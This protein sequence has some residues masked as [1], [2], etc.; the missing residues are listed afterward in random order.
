MSQIRNDFWIRLVGIALLTALALSSDDIYQQAITGRVLVKLLLTL[1]TIIITWHLNRAIIIAYQTRAAFAKNGSIRWLLIFLSCTV[2]TTVAGWLMKAAEY[3]L[4][5]GT[6]RG[7]VSQMDSIS[8][9]LNQTTLQLST[10]GLDWLHGL[11]NALFYIGVYRIFF[12]LAD[13]S[14]YRQRLAQVEQEKEQLRISNLQSQLEVLKQQVNPHFLF[15]ALNSLSA[16]IAEDPKQAEAFVD[17]LSGVYR[18]VLRANEQPLTT[19]GA[20]L[21]FLD[22]Y[23]HLLKT[24]YGD[25]LFLS[26]TVDAAHQASQLPPLTLQL[27]VENAVKHNVVSS[28]RPLHIHIASPSQP[29]LLVSNTLQRKQSRVLSNGVGLSNILAKYQLL[30]LPAPVVTQTQDAFIVRLPLL[31]EPSI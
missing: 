16:L 7:L 19:L 29:E 22:A 25:G 2:A 11:L 5:H 1:T 30:D 27:L 23:Y 15:N 24:R 8:L 31:I 4:I 13:S 21:Q 10:N 12:F 26:V 3:S 20:E 14:M 28:K 9:T 17:K 6:L 18:Y